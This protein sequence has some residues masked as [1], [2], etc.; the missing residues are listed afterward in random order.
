[1]RITRKRLRKLIRESLNQLV[2]EEVSSFEI[3]CFSFK[4]EGIEKN[5]PSVK[6]AESEDDFDSVRENASKAQIYLI[7]QLK[8]KSPWKKKS[9]LLIR[10]RKDNTGQYV[11]ADHAAYIFLSSAEREEIASHCNRENRNI[12]S[13]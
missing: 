9:D 5:L 13:K 7:S 12:A 8:N 11:V 3:V 10:V 4:E 2:L 6:F 1:M